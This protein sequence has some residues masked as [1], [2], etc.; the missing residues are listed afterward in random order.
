GRELPAILES[1]HRRLHLRVRSTRPQQILYLRRK[2]RV[3]LE[4]RVELCLPVLVGIVVALRVGTGLNLIVAAALAVSLTNR[5][6]VSRPS[7]LGRC[8]RTTQEYKN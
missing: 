4:T 8:R 6:T 5:R 1:H 2:C 3:V 7:S